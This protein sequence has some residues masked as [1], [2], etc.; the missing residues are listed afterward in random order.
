MVALN[1]AADAFDAAL[2]TAEEA[3][4]AANVSLGEFEASINTVNSLLDSL[5]VP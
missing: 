1:N 4:A 2:R 5:G 3:Q